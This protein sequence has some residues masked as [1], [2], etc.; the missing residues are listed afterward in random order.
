MRLER[1]IDLSLTVLAVVIY[2]RSVVFVY[3]WLP[4]VYCAGPTQAFFDWYS[5]LAIAPLVPFVGMIVALLLARRGMLPVVRG[6]VAAASTIAGVVIARI[7]SE[8]MIPGA[9]GDCICCG[10][11]S[12]SGPRDMQPPLVL[13]LSPV[14]RTRAATG[15]LVV[16][17][18]VTLAILIAENR[19]TDRRLRYLTIVAVSLTVFFC[20]GWFVARAP[21]FI[22]WTNGWR[23]IAV[24]CGIA[25]IAC[26]A[27]SVSIVRK[28]IVAF[29][30][31][32]VFVALSYVVIYRAVD[33]FAMMDR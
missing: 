9:W 21:G 14:A 28:S 1:A 29:V 8:M 23:Y 13:Q 30:A 6:I 12:P 16:M 5:L 31:A 32:L 15:A 20:A 10:G 11:P 7:F 33:F 24:M 2:S 17:T 4:I 18:L 22:W 25:S 3:G 26:V 19:G 27:G